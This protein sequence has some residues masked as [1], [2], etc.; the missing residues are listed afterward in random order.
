MLF[1]YLKVSIRNI[2]GQKFYA[3]INIA[4]L[5]IGLASFVLIS[6]YIQ[7][8]LSYD[9]M[10]SKADRTF[11]LSEK[12]EAEG[13][14]EHSASLP[15]PV[16]PTLINDFPSQVESA[17]RLFNFQSPTLSLANRKL[18]KEFNEARI[19]FAD[20][21]FFKVFD[22]NLVSGDKETALYDPN[23]ILITKTMADKYFGDEDP[24][25]QI[26]EFQ[27][28]HNYVVKGVLEDAPLNAHFQFDFII[29]FA[30]LKAFYNGSYPAGWY[31]NPC[32]TYVVLSEN[33]TKESL[34]A[35][36]PSFIEKYF[37]DF[38]KEDVTL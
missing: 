16:A 13:V 21:A 14:G 30:S 1:N 3:A 31:W 18:D 9:R 2:A 27:G 29:S 8:E 10:H 34:I 7:D 37:P 36:F 28:T 24:M 25:G 23:T 15:F 32:W 11:R 4:G 19:F 22:F 38:V 20:S 12:F 6:L 35:Q 33:S 17:V 5:A 26:L